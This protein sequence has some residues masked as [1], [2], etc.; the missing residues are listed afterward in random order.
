MTRQKRNAE[1]F[2]DQTLNMFLGG[3]AVAEAW[4]PSAGRSG[5]LELVGGFRR[6]SSDQNLVGEVRHRDRLQSGEPMVRR[7][8]HL[9]ALLEPRPAIEALMQSPIFDEESDIELPVQQ[10]FGQTSLIGL[11]DL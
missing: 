1:P 6:S 11:D 3:T 7:K 8:D 5:L 2:S 10:I 9:I 4:H